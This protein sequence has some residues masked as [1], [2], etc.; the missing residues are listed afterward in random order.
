MLCLPYV[1]VSFI[2]LQIS[3]RAAVSEEDDL[4]CEGALK[5]KCKP[6]QP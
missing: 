4:V 2:F 1:T 5:P 6:L 3:A